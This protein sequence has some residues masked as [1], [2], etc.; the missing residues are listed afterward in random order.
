M[1]GKLGRGQ[2]GGRGGVVIDLIDT[3]LEAK[4]VERLYPYKRCISESCTISLL[5]W[6]PREW[7]FNIIYEVRLVPS[8]ILKSRG[9]LP[10]LPI[11]FP[12][13]VGP[14]ENQARLTPC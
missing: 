5:C 14:S 10:K 8:L 1:Y 3:A 7:E 13:D 11:I 4:L 12:S 9:R 2:E 6:P